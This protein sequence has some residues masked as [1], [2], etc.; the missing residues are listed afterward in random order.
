MVTAPMDSDWAAA[1][2][3]TSAPTRAIVKG[4]TRPP[5]RTEGSTFSGAFDD[6]TI[7]DDRIY[8]DS[9]GARPTVPPALTQK[10]AASRWHR[11]DFHMA[12]RTP[13]DD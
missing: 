10:A 13:T 9:P 4:Q 7:L 5:T 3:G 8:E 12:Q 6:L 11:S 2:T 1:G